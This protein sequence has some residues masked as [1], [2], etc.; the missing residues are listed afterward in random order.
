M[1]ALVAGWF[2]RYPVVT[3]AVRPDPDLV[4]GSATTVTA[5]EW[6]R[7]LYDNPGA[8]EDIDEP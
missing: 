6:G 7:P 1:A 2:L 8:V 3:V 4:A 5:Y